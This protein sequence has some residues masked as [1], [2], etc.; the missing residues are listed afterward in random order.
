[1]V[2]VCQAAAV[3]GVPFPGGVF[4]IHRV[5]QAPLLF[6]SS[7]RGEPGPRRVGKPSSTAAP[8]SHLLCQDRQDQRPFEG[9]VGACRLGGMRRPLPAGLAEGGCHI[10]FRGR[11]AP[12]NEPV[13]RVRL[14]GLQGVKGFGVLEIRSPP[15]EPSCTV[16]P[17]L[18]QNWGLMCTFLGRTTSKYSKAQ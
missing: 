16:L 8:T 1:M 6:R 13:L 11:E 2:Q 9:R 14:L 7:H 15:R 10:Y 18:M 4:T 5:I 12:V 17:N 3:E